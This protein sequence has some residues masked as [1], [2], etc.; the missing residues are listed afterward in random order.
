M[1][2]RQV[3]ELAEKLTQ[4]V[5]SSERGAHAL[6]GVGAAARRTLGGELAVDDD[7]DNGMGGKDEQRKP[8][9]SPPAAPDPMPVDEAL[10][11]LDAAAERGDAMAWAATLRQQLD[12]ERAHDLAE[13]RRRIAAQ[14]QSHR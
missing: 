4:M 8:R 10:A 5:P 7:D 2:S 11:A 9:A 12:A 14:R 3:D 1:S 13:R 6:G